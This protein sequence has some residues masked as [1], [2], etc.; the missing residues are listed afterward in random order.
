M[1]EA[2]LSVLDISNQN[3]SAAQ[4]EL[5]R[6]HFRLGHLNYASVQLVLKSGSLGDSPLQKSAARCERPKCASCRFANAKQ[7]STGYQ[8]SV[9]PIE[10]H[11]IQT[12]DLIPGQRVSVDHFTV[13]EKGSV[14]RVKGTNKR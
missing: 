11:S 5:L 8:H 3:L 2:N 14:I 7:R 13:T 1:P 4:K 10:G 12:N 6:W 9:T